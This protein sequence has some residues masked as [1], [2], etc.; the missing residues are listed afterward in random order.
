MMGFG[1]VILDRT[2][3]IAAAAGFIIFRRLPV[4]K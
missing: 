4:S 3:V 2:G 1:S